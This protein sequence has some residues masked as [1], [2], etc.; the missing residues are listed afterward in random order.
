MCSVQYSTVQS[1]GRQA[2]DQAVAHIEAP[3]RRREEEAEEEEEEEPEQK[4]FYKEEQGAG[5]EY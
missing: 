4:K 1:L 5:Q 2:A 3:V